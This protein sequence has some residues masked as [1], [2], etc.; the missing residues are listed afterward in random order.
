MIRTPTASD[1]EHIKQLAVAVGMFS[2]DEVGFFD[3]ILSGVLA[4][5]L[6]DHRWL[7][8]ER[9]SGGV[10]GAAYFAPEPFADRVWNLYFIAVAPEAQGQGIGGMLIGRVE[11]EL[12][13]AGDDVARVLIV[14]TSSTEQYAPARAFYRSRGY[15]E[16]A[17]IRQFY[18]PADD[19]I[20]Y[21]KSLT[22][23]G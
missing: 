20:V 7:L 21:W 18:G 17:R 10:G 14:E 8:A 1:V 2:V 16:E 23:A 13:A 4:G 11:R 15:D 9:E 3:E 5:T 6:A 12:V 22:G 19:K